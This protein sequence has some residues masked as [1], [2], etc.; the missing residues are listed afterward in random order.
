MTPEEIITYEMDSMRQELFE[1]YSA[2]GKIEQ[3]MKH[4][5]AIIAITDSRV[6]SDSYAKEGIS[7]SLDKL[8][9]IRTDVVNICRRL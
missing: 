4:M 9:E 2:I 3:C 1:V 5:E 6:R 8:T 7:A